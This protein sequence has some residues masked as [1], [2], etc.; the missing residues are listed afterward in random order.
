MRSRLPDGLLRLAPGQFGQQGD[1]RQARADVVVDVLG[2]A[3]A[4]AFDGVLLFQPRQL[5]RYFGGDDSARGKRHATEDAGNGQ[6]QKP[7]RLVKIRLNG[8]INRRT[9]L[10]PNAVVVAGDDLEMVIARRQRPV[11]R[12]AP[13]LGIHP[14]CVKPVNPVAEPRLVARVKIQR[15]KAE[16]ILLVARRHDDFPAMDR[17]GFAVHAHFL[18]EH[19]RRRRLGDS[20]HPD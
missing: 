18:D 17:D 7:G 9:G 16:I 4:V 13:R 2:D 19:R 3:G 1:L 6:D 12:R 11:M 5:R 15:G 10:V 14:V 20:T 8:K